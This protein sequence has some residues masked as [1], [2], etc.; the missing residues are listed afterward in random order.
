MSS[1]A[2][3][4][5]SRTADR[6]R[7]CKRPGPDAIERAKRSEQAAHPLGQT[8]NGLRGVTLDIPPGGRASPLSGIYPLRPFYFAR[9]NIDREAGAI[10]WPS[11]ISERRRALTDHPGPRSMSASETG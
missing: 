4:P 3:G 6:T 1:A 9:V 10:A 2:H 7:G 11:G 8:A 5:K